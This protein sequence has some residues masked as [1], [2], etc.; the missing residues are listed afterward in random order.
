MISRL[1]AVHVTY[2]LVYVNGRNRTP[3][4]AWNNTFRQIFISYSR[5][6]ILFLLLHF[7]TVIRYWPVQIAVLEKVVSQ[8]KQLVE[9]VSFNMAL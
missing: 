9:S 1:N 2:S 6:N 8:W 5:E 7:T 3:S 4:I